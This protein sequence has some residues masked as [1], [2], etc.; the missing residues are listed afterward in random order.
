[1]Q[2]LYVK[3][4]NAEELASDLTSAGIPHEAVSCVGNLIT[5]TT[6]VPLSKKQEETVREIVVAQYSPPPN[7]EVSL[8]VIEDARAY[9]SKL[10]SEFAAENVALGLNASQVA[11]IAAKYA[12]FVTLLMSGSIRTALTALESMP[13]DPVIGDD[14]KQRFLNKLRKYLNI[15]LR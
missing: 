2:Y 1:M 14:R 12:P 6:S 10:I 3:V 5:I 4:V 15:P 7:L 13:T 9:G 8:E 11:Y